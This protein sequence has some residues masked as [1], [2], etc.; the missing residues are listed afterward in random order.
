LS[1]APF[2]QLHTM[3]AMEAVAHEATTASHSFRV[4]ACT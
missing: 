4:M 3:A 1:S 2:R